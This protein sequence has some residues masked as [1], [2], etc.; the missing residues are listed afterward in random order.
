MGFAEE[1]LGLTVWSRQRDVLTAAAT[2]KQV[3]VRA[4][5]KVS[6]SASI[7]ALA[8]WNTLARGQP[9]L[10]TSSSYSQLKGIIWKEVATLATRANLG[11]DVPL[12][13]ETGIRAGNGAEITG[14]S[15]N[16]REYMQGYSGADALYL[17]DEA[18]GLPT[19]IVEAL[20]G[21]LAGGGRLMLFGNPT[22]LSGPFYD[23]FHSHRAS[24]HGIRI[25]SRESPNVTGEASIPGLAVPEWIAEQEQKHGGPDSPFV[26]IHVDGDFPTSGSNSVISLAL[27]ES[28]MSRTVEPSPND[29]LHLGV[30]VA[31]FGSDHTTVR[32]RRG[33]LAYPSRKARGTDSYAVAR[34]V[35]ETVAQYAVPGERPVVKVDVIGIGAGTFDVL[36]TEYGH[37]VEVIAVNVAE[38][39]TAQPAEGGGYRR[40]RDQL[41]FATRDWLAE[42]GCLPQDEE[43]RSDLI[44]PTFRFDAQGRYVVADKDEL[45]KSIGRS[46][47]D[48]DALALSIY[49]PPPAFEPAE[50]LGW[51]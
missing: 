21:N 4:G 1:V 29:V 51:H 15:T 31:R 43:T 17:A 50:P 40:L 27:V 44:A 45:R 39:A 36:K 41:W 30:D 37:Q 9:T 20:E 49:T 47:D 26:Q 5:R 28:A 3:A 16:K 13:P 24:W 6:K 46:P 7:A 14:R 11:L 22:Q 32:P 10:L 38:S 35:M 19:F 12:D 42:G 8:L 34:L 33:L 23:A 25:S 48:G 18:S 2:H